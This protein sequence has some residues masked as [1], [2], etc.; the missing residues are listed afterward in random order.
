[1]AVRIAGGLLAQRPAWT[2]AKLADRLNDKQQRLEELQL[3]DLAVRTSFALS[4]DAL[5]DDAQRVFRRLSALAGPDFGPG[6]VA[7]LDDS[8][9]DAIERVLERLADAQLVESPTEDRYRL[10]DLIALFA[11]ERAT[12]QEPVDARQRA[13]ARARGWYLQHAQLADTLLDAPSSQPT[14]GDLDA[15]SA[16]AWARG[17]F[18]LER[19]N[20]VATI[21][22]AHQLQDWQ[23]TQQL[24]AS[25]TR[26][27][28]LRAHWD[29]WQHTHQLA[30]DATRHAG[31][32]HGEAQTLMNLGSVYARQGRWQDAIGC[33]EQSLQTMRELGDRH[34]E[35]QTLGNLG[36][37]L[38]AHGDENGAK[39]HL[40]DALAL[41]ET[42]GAPETETVRAQLQSKPRRPWSRRRRPATP[43]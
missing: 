5:D 3:A 37:A 43:S 20:L 39:R 40:G 7:A 38:R 30:L 11:G 21:E 19:A 8:N 27:L 4:Y 23:S 28:S 2:L 16:R 33:Y 14:L 10:H 36:L 29:D 18:A 41:F 9:P 12:D 15:A 1:L 31:D 17:W 25:L 34:G 32:R 24:A 42:L 35:A 26:F 22:Q 6:V 13:A